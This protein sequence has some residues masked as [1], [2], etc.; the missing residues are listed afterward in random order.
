MKDS[1]PLT[2]TLKFAALCLAIGCG[3][4]ESKEAEKDEDTPACDL[5]IAEAGRALN[6]PIGS[7]ITLNGNGS[8]WCEDYAPFQIN[9]SWNFERVPPDSSVTESAFSENLTSTANRPT[10]MPDLPGEYVVSLRINDPSNAS[11]PDFTVITVSSDDL[12]PLA[13]CGDDAYGRVGTA[14]RLDGSNSSDPEGARLSYNWGISSTPECSRLT[15]TNIFDQGTANPSVIPDCQGLYVISLVVDDG[16]QWSSADY[17]TINVRSDNRAPVAEA[18]AG[19]TLPPCTSNPFTLGGWE[20]YDPDGDDLSY[21]WSVVSAPTGADAS[22]YGFDDATRVDPRFT[23]DVPGEWTFQLQVGDGSQISSPDIVTY[24]IGSADD[25]NSPTA[26][27][28]G[29]QTVIVEANCSTS[30]YVWTCDDCAKTNYP[31][32][33]TGSSDPDGDT[34]NYNWSISDEGID[35]T[36]STSAVANVVLP[37]KPSE[38]DVDITVEYDVTLNVNDCS[39]DDVDRMTLTHI[40]RG[41]YVL[42]DIP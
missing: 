38:Y 12:K 17:C 3:D 37:A 5:P 11:D 25:N 33:G 6:A 28:G 16:I 29:D 22:A 18:G 23:W 20:S 40:C 9:Y 35:W 4:S 39:L 14:T 7:S 30:S 13:D 8:S 36:S 42:P 27:A 26:N 1:L 19:G 34:L 24:L 10:F 31:L 21:S 2:S 15:N 32:D 41:I